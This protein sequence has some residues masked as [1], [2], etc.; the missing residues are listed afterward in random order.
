MPFITHDAVR[1][2]AVIGAGTIGASWSA[3]FLARGLTVRVSDPAPAAPDMVR[4][5]VREAWPA[6]RQLRITEE[7]VDQALARLSFHASAG[8]AAQGADFVQENAPE[9][10]AV[11][12]AVLKEID[13]VVPADRVIASSTSGF[14]VTE[15]Q[16]EM[17][18]PERLV[19]G[20]PFNPPHLIPLVEVVGGGRSSEEA[21]QWAIGFYNH[22]GKRAIHVRKEVPGHIA[23]RLQA[24]LWREALH[25]VQEGV[26]SVDDIDAAIAYGPGLRWAIMGPHLTFHLAGGRGGIAH[27]FDHLGPNVE[28]WWADLGTPHITP[29]LRDMIARGVE[30]EIAGR[31]YESLVEHR[32]K[33]LLGVLAATRQPLPA[34]E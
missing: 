7:A 2:I 4:A 9:R 5:Y 21:V 26:G 11:K 17:R 23:N 8:E 12:Q 32:D 25:L 28:K 10:V 27:F 14:G 19:V 15:M 29:E 31:S 6:L 13:A 24:A 22:V 34:E 3:W 20:H 1:T 16:A 30:E 18:H 33:A